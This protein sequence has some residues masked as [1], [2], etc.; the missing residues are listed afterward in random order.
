[1]QTPCI[2]RSTAGGYRARRWALGAGLGLVV[3]ATGVGTADAQEPT[4]NDRLDHRVLAPPSQAY[5]GLTA[6]QLIIALGLALQGAPPSMWH[7]T[8]IIRPL[9]TTSPN[10]DP[11][12]R[13]HPLPAA[14]PLLAATTP[15]AVPV[16]ASPSPR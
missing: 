2:C 12:G 13:T 8:L 7:D 9:S 15:P 11:S 4:I 1:M 14:P 5:V 10:R 16:A 6:G 3:L